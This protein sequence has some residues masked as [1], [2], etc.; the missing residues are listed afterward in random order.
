MK[1]H[2]VSGEVKSIR[3]IHPDVA[4]VEGTID[5]AAPDG[6]KDESH[7]SAIWV[8]TDGKWVI[9][10]ARDLPVEVAAG[11]SLAYSHL[12]PLEWLLGEWVDQSPKGEVQL[13][14]HWGSNKAFLLMNFQVRREG[15]EPL[16]V[17]VRVGWDPKNAVIR[18]W[19][20]DSQGGFAEGTWTRNGH[21]WMVDTTGVLPDGG[22]GSSVNTWEYVDG[23]SFVWRATD[24]VVDDQP[25][26]DVEV[27]FVR[28][29]QK[30]T[31]AKQ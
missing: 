23:K 21:R 14:C 1:D 8:K 3:M 19:V 7:Y 5:Y 16:A 26:G 25:I 2:K 28:K 24:R 18:S 22:T 9:S 13:S 15:Q 27:R 30:P 10:S 11:P 20:F 29:A 31:E 12:R 17:A 6:S 4:M